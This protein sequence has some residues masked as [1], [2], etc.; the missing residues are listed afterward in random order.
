MN[1]QRPEWNDANNALAGYG[2]SMVT[3]CYLRRFLVSLELLVDDHEEEKFV[4]SIEV[5][6]LFGAI[7]EVFKKYTFVLNAA[8]RVEDRKSIMDELGYQGEQYRENVY[9]GFSGNKSG[10]GKT[11]LLAFVDVVKTY[12][13]HS[14]ALNRREDGLFHSY[15]LIQF[16]AGGY[17]VE[18]LYEMLEGQVAVLSS[19]YLDAKGSLDLLSALRSSKMYRA[20][21]NSYVLY[22]DRKLP[23]FHEK[24]V[25][26]QTKIE[27]NTWIQNEL[28]SGRNNFIEQD[29]NG[30]VHFNG[31]FKNAEELRTCLEKD[32]G[33]SRKDRDVLCNV[34]ETVFNHRQFTGRSGTMFKYEGLGCIYWH[35]VSKLLLATGEVVQSAG[36]NGADQ[37]LMNQ[38]LKHFDD[39]KDGLGLHKSP[40]QYGA[41]PVDPYSHTTGF[42]GVQQ[43]GMTGQVKEDV[44]T[45]FSELGVNVTDGEISFSPVMLKR[46]EFI[47]EPR[48]WQFSVG[49]S[50][51]SEDLDSGSL[52]FSLCGVPVIYRLAEISSIQVHLDKN[53][54]EVIEGNKLGVVWSQSLFKREKRVLKLIVDLPA[55]RLRA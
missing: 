6:S 47:S 1:T 45:R 40:A 22:P 26:P 31:S 43:P 39:I 42:S 27:G 14:I 12:L 11:R 52:A 20:D 50:I 4:V 35:M 44:I 8:I 9:T 46:Q 53:E 23:L 48:T 19:G 55:A 16:G 21:Q 10:L 32:T 24:N 15:N 25:I 13:D 34:Y 29:V 28:N 3:L 49:G 5:L 41:F 33:I 37:Q 38:L 36:K 17:T 2:L 7:E 18:N 54:I 30:I 51:R